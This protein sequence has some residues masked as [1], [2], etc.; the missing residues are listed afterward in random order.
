MLM[1]C[2]YR[3]NDVLWVFR[4]CE[5]ERRSNLLTERLPQTIAFRSQERDM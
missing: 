5:E 2:E 1:R 4:P 3:T